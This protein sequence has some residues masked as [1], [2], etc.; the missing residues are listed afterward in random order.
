MILALV[1][2]TLD[3]LPSPEESILDTQPVM[4]PLAF[5]HFPSADFIAARKRAIKRQPVNALGSCPSLVELLLHYIRVSREPLGARQY[6]EVLP[7]TL[8]HMLQLNTPFYH[9]YDVDP[10]ENARSRRKQAQ[11]G[12]RLMYLTN[13]SLIIVPSN[14]VAQWNSE[15]L[16]HCL[17]GLRVLVLKSTTQMPQAKVLASD[18]DVS[19]VSIQ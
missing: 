15:I 13:A 16:K 11:P 6:E 3:Q 7:D 10:A 18:Y 4:T 8:L 19:T 5:R 2:A 1:L 12:P 9:H 17:S 14:L